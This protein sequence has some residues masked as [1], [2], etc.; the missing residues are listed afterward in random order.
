MLMISRLISSIGC[1]VGSVLGQTICKEIHLMGV[2]LGK[3]YSIIG[4]SLGLFPAMGP[5]IGGWISEYY[6][7]NNI[8]LFLSAFGL[9]LFLMLT[10]SFK[11]DSR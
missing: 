11:R 8:F 6:G 7:W 4:M 5:V 2:N 9:I 3:V 1:S 10:F